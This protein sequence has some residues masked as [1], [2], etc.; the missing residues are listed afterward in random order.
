MRYCY[1]DK[2]MLGQGAPDLVFCVQQIIRGV[3]VRV[4]GNP[5]DSVPHKE[6]FLNEECNNV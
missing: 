4:S 3:E 2:Q 1:S 6:L 5:T